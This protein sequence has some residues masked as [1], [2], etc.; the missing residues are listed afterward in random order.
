M[1]RL[2]FSIA[3]FWFL[4]GL[5]ASSSS[6]AEKELCLVCKVKEGA[7]EPE[8]VKASRTYEEVRYG[9]CSEPCAQEFDSDPLAYVPASFPRPAP[10]LALTD[11][12][13]NSLSWESYK[14]KVVL[15]DFWAT[16][17]KPCR[18]SMPELQELH[19]K[20]RGQGFSV[21]G[22]SI[23]EGDPKKVEKFVA[24]E[25]ITYPIAIDAD[26]LPAWERFRVKTIP[27]AFLVDQNGS[28]VAQWT[29]I[30]ADIK[31]IEEKLAS[32]LSPSEAK[33]P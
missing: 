26:K 17:C 29:G 19:D 9:F 20:Y 13:Q 5:A 12:S 8:V 16:W 31:E 3:I 27:A 4:A 21:I 11:L 14:G 30:P 22:I 18:K 33:K 10:D 23:D 24:S 1:K 7:T 15:V 6:A 28:I 25:E 32:L 2:V